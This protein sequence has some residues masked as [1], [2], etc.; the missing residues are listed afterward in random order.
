[1]GE[2]KERMAKK[3]LMEYRNESKEKGW[4]ERL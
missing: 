2:K 1:M 4:R 3:E